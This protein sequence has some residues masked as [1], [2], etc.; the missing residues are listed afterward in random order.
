M[1]FYD[2]IQNAK[3]A[4]AA[5]T[6]PTSD[7]I[8]ALVLAASSEINA[9][10]TKLDTANATI[11]T[12]TATIASDKTQISALTAQVTDLQNKL[13]AVPPP[14]TTPAPAPAMTPVGGM[15]DCHLHADLKIGTGADIAPLN[16]G[17]VAGTDFGFRQFQNLGGS[18]RALELYFARAIAGDYSGFL[19]SIHRKPVERTAGTLIWKGKFFHDDRATGAMQALEFDTLITKGGSKYNLSSQINYAKGGMLQIVNDASGNKSWQDSGL[20]VGKLLANQWN[21][22]QWEYQ[23]DTVAKTFGYVAFTLNGKRFPVPAGQFTSQVPTVSNWSDGLHMQ[24]Q[25]GTNSKGLPFSVAF[26]D[27]DY[28]YV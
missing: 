13:A 20:V 19:V 23:F 10:L 6:Q 4:L 5:I 14:A 25:I 27:L 18:N 1:A 17:L 21:T 26:D 22:I 9:A 24:L 8:D 7:A 15:H 12:Q 11:T 3:Q 16:G 2:Q 28:W